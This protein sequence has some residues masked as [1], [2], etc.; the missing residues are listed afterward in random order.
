MAEGRIEPDHGHPECSGHRR[1]GAGGHAAAA[2]EQDSLVQEVRDPHSQLEDATTP[3]SHVVDENHRRRCL[4]WTVEW[5]DDAGHRSVS[6]V[7]ETTDLQTA[8]ARVPLPTRP[9]GSRPTTR[10]NPLNA[11]D[12]PSPGPSPVRDQSILHFYLVRPHTPSAARVL[13]PVPHTSSISDVLRDQVV[14]EFPTFYVLS[15]AEDALPDG[16]ITEQEFLDSARRGGPMAYQRRRGPTA[17][18]DDP[19]KGEGNAN[20]H[21]LGKE[22]EQAHADIRHIMHVLTQ[23]IVAGPAGDS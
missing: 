13:I 7:F 14:L 8:Y 2:R 17:V 12:H 20:G 10:R 11:D 19:T 21:Q 1:E 3:A 9:D 23:D 18:K 15:S 6:A 16:F 5:I 4:S 22:P